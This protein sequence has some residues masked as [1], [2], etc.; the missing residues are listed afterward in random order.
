MEDLL[1]N[2]EIRIFTAG[3]EIRDLKIFIRRGDLGRVPEI[4]E[5]EA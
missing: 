4:A 3:G 1:T 5:D 2:R